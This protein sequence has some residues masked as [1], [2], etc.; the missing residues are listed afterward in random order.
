M[1]EATAAV[2]KVFSG[3]LSDVLGKRK[4]RLV[5]GYALA[6]FTKPV[7]PLAP[8]IR[9]SRWGLHMALTQGLFAKLVAGALWSTLG[10]SATFVAGAALAAA[11][12]AGL[13]GYR[14]S[15][16]TEAQ[17]SGHRGRD[18]TIGD[19]TEERH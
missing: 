9:W 10:A 1:A 6:A 16:H 15:G 5:L 4:F 17:G 19:T 14:Q 11:A 12:A 3:T 7:F 8:T 2:T 13:L 18:R